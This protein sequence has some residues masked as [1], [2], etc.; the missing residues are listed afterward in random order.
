MPTL[1]VEDAERTVLV[2]LEPGAAIVLGRAH[3]CDVPVVAPRVSRRHAVVEDSPTGFRV[4]DLGSTNGTRV[5]E[6]PLEG[7]CLLGDGDVVDLGG[8]RVVFRSAPAAAERTG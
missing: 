3:A 6:A 7:E 8:C 2:D 1:I 4:R 5:N